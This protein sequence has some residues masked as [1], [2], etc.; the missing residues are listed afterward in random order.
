[1]VSW[2]TFSALRE[3]RGVL[4]YILLFVGSEVSWFCLEASHGQQH[5]KRKSRGVLV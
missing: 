1:M 5:E 2:V 4:V 3:Q